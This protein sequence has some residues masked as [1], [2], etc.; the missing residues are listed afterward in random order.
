V[1]SDDAPVLI[2]KTG[3]LN[4][5]RFPLHD[6]L[7][8]GRDA[9]CD[10]TI[11]DRQVSRYHVRFQFTPEGVKM[12]DLGSKNGTHCNGQPIIEPILLQ[13]GDVIQIALVQK[14]LFAVSD[15][16]ATMPLE[17][18]M[19]TDMGFQSPRRLRL[20]TRSRRVWVNDHE[21]LPP[22]SVSQFRLLELLYERDGK[23]V[24]RRE[25]SG[26]VWGDEDAVDVSEQALDALVRRLRD[27]L[28]ALDPTHGYII[29]VRGHG[30]RLDNPPIKV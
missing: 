12:E 16:T 30:L 19:E 17:T 11:A 13:D 10:I 23:V 5:H 29:T 27:R 7:L 9:S 24:D 8:M 20:E 25:M 4:G 14:F 22:L 1:V 3:P 2:G 18:M 21:L 15:A 6:N 26:V 28:A